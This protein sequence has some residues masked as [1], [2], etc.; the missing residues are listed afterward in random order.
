MFLLVSLLILESSV[1]VLRSA[2]D[3]EASLVV[4]IEHLC[5]LLRLRDL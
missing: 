3:F 2:F 1:N 5:Y 4:S